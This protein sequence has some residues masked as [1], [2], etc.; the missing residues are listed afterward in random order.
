M[1]HTDSVFWSW[2]SMAMIRLGYFVIAR[3]SNTKI[4]SSK[5]AWR[6]WCLINLSVLTGNILLMSGI[7]NGGGEYREYIWP[8]AGLFLLGLIITFA[9]FYKTVAQRKISEIY[10][11][12]WYLDRKSTRLNSS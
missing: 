8:V 10:V 7:N 2:A 9:N 4:H 6:G 5:W 12:N 1:V 11:S 3:T